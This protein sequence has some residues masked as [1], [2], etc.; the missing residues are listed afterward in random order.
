MPYSRRTF[1]ETTLIAGTALAGASRLSAGAPLLAESARSGDFELVGPSSEPSPTNAPPK[2]AFPVADYHVHLS[3]TLT[4]D[5]A[6]QLAKDRG[7]QIGILEHPGPG[8]PLNTDAD[9]QR[10]I[11]KLRKYPVRIGVQPVY[12]G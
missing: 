3:N 4:I 1:L 6:L 2:L 7:V 12:P 5:R 11:D 10:Y 9:L 8:F